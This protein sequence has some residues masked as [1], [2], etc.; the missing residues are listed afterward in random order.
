MIKGIGLS[1]GI[2]IGSAF[3]LQTY[4][5]PSI[6]KITDVTAQLNKVDIAVA[7]AGNGIEH[8]LEE[9]GDSLSKDQQN[10]LSTHK[11]LIEDDELTSQI[12]EMIRT[13]EVDAVYAV[14][15]VTEKL[16]ATFE[17]MDNDYFKERAVD[18]RDIG[19]QLRDVLEGRDSKSHVMDAGSIVIA[20]DLTP[21]DT[22]KLDL[23]KV[24]GF[25]TET[26][27][28]TS[29]SAIIARSLNIPAVKASGAVAAVSEG[30]TV[31]IDGGSGQVLV[32][33]VEEVLINYRAKVEEQRL[34]QAELEALR[35]EE[36]VTLDGHRVEVVGNIV[37]SSLADEVNRQGGAGIGL[38]RSE[39][40]YMESDIAPDEDK[41]FE[42]YRHAAE[43]M[44]GKPVVVRTLDVGGDKEIAYLGIEKEANPFMGFRAI[45]YCLKNDD[46]FRTQIRALLRASHYGHI[47]IML[48][49]IAAVEELRQAK[50]IIEACKR[51]LASE[52][53]PFNDE[54]PVGIMIEVPSAAVMSY[55]LAQE[56]D[57]FSIGTNDLIGYTMAADRMNEHV[58]YLYS[59]HQPAVLELIR[60]TIEN[61]HRAGITVS[62][63]GNSAANPELIPIYLGMGLDR[64]SVNPS[65]IPKVK[66]LIR[67]LNYSE[68]T[69]L[70][71]CSQNV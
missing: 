18:M 32:N 1:E 14:F 11:M 23:S 8:L 58:A 5:K 38:Y 24:E 9:K 13:E 33:P 57:F 42:A 21:S 45:R 50:V 71:V 31:V 67:S 25:V 59:D 49:M 7:E 46:I 34:E 20:H 44:K 37:T 53:L 19:K 22:V 65:E 3:L 47:K 6:K 17:A 41:Q 61:G 43:M 29:H 16:A 48:P 27:G 28:V 55:Q 69:E 66:R 30:D 68:C 62:M 2:A 70:T 26:G 35:D 63:C 56:A 39:F 60:M 64:F 54:V 36:A 51:E 40:L 15:T 12:H 52:N 10:I 4:E